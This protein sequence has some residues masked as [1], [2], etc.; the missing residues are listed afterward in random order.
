MRILASAAGLTLLGDF[1]LWPAT[2]GLSW[3]LFVLALGAAVVLNRPRR[4]WSRRVALWL[5]LLLATACQSAVEI[6]FSNVLV[7]LALIIVLVGESSYPGLAPGW[8]RASEALWALAKAPGRWLWASAAAAK[9]AWANT[10]LSG[11]AVRG[12][13]ICLP[14][15]VLCAV[16][17]GIFG[18]GNAIFGSWL[19]TA[20]AAFRR[21][22]EA[23]DLSIP[24]LLLYGL[25]ATV[26]LWALRP[27]NPGNSRR[28]WVRAIPE[29]P[30]PHPTIAW[31]RGVAILVLLN[32]LF[33]SVNTIDA[34]YLWA[35]RSLPAG[36]NASRYVHEGVNSLIAAALLSAVVLAVLFQQGGGTGQSPALKR[37]GYVWIAQNFVLIAGVILRLV[38]YIQDF[39]LTAAR[40]Y[41]IS[42]VLLVAVGFA[43]LAIHI[44]WKRSL[45]GLILSNGLA[46]LVLFFVM[47]FLNVGGWVA[48]YNVVRWKLNPQKGLDLDYLVSLGAPAW[49][50]LKQA[51]KAGLPGSRDAAKRLEHS[52]GRERNDREHR[53]WRSWQARRAIYCRLLKIYLWNPKTVQEVSKTN[54]LGGF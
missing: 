2:P 21:W 3:G 42:F 40:V 14:A 52:I 49:P 18:E 1:L 47:Q 54:F 6:S 50:A 34:L 11:A 22:L 16:F 20:F 46:T 29:I 27:S 4:V 38:C 37:L 51:A 30:V 35:H 43:L 48:H 31:W 28:I 41:A 44:A 45:N 9:F 36:V 5:A 33:F 24:H 19:A 7:S 23:L 53:D 17:A 12:L 8:E 26:A 13:R 10:G 15:L 39:Q 25:L 32:G